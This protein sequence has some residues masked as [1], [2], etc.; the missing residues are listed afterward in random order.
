M[1]TDTIPK[2]VQEKY[3]EI[4]TVDQQMKAVQQKMEK[5]E[6]Q[7]YEL[8]SVIQD[9]DDMKK[10]EK[11]ADALVPVHNGIFLKAKILDTDH[12]HVNV[13]SGTV[14]EKTV[15]EVKQIL[16][17]QGSEIKKTQKELESH[18]NQLLDRLKQLD[19]EITLAMQKNV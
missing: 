19:E 15:E 4:Q 2:D 8:L 16:V 18:F 13:G 12:L 5:L 3:I 9:M 1:K 7:Y 14:V 17:S 6:E 11:N 10:V